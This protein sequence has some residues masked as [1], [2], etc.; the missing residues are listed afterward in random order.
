MGI[1]NQYK[2][3]LVSVSFRKSSPREILRAMSEAGLVCVEWGSDIH[4]PCC[5]IEGLYEIAALQKEYGI[6]CSSYGTYFRLGESPLCELENHIKAAKI[7][8]TDILRIWCGIKSGA[9]MSEGEKDELLSSCRAAAKLAETYGVTLCTECHK[10]TFT[11]NTEDAAWLMRA[12][13]SPHFCTYWQPFQW[14]TAKENIENARRLSEF[15]RHIHVFNW[16]GREKLPLAEAIDEWRGYLAEFSDMPSRAL[17]LEFMPN[18]SIGELSD[19]AAALRA[20][21]GEKI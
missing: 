4:A 13:G 2:L 15:T 14:Q 6:E 10:K 9:D 8:G 16:K 17:L 12:V 11:E 19:E 5:D 7:L 18:G 20:I 3:G 1:G 21:V